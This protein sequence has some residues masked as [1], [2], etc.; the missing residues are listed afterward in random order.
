[1]NEKPGLS[2]ALFARRG[3]GGLTG[4]AFLN[5]HGRTM[6]ISPANDDLRQARM[7]DIF[8]GQRNREVTYAGISPS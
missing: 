1:M 5:G 7:I 3:V 6:P 2:R 8:V 4:H